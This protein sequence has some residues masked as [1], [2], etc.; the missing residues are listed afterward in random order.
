[1]RDTCRSAVPSGYVILALLKFIFINIEISDKAIS[2]NLH[3]LLKHVDI[4]VNFRHWE[5]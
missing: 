1:M 2:E 4:A 5:V 3:N